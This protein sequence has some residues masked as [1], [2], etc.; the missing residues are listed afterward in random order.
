MAVSAR[1]AVR[2]TSIASFFG[3]EPPRLL[4]EIGLELAQVERRIMALL[5]EVTE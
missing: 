1:W 5:R 4:E 3:F 2:S